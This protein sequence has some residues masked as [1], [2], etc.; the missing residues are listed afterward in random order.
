MNLPETPETPAS[1]QNIKGHRNQTIGS[2]SGNSRA[3]G[4]VE[5]NVYN[6]T[7]QKQERITSLFDLPL[8]V[9]D[10]VGRVDEL[11]QIKTALS[12]VSETISVPI[13]AVSGMAGVGKSALALHAGNSLS[14]N[15]PDAL[16][17]VDLQGDGD[18][19]KAPSDVLETWL[20]AFGLAPSEI[21]IT[22]EAKR[23]SFLTQIR[24][25]KALIV[26]DNA[27]NENQVRP[28]L[29]GGQDCAVLV[30]SR[31]SLTALK[32][33]QEIRLTPLPQKDSLNLLSTLAG[34]ARV[35][36]EYTAA[37]D[38]VRLCG[39]LPLAIRI[40]G[41]TLREK[42]HWGLKVDYLPLL[43]DEK[44][45]IKQLKQLRGEDVRASF[46]L[47]YQQLSKPEQ[48]LF[49]LLGALPS[50]FSI[51]AASATSKQPN[52][53]VKQVIEQLI[54]AQLLGVKLTESEQPR[55]QYHDLIRLFAKDLLSPEDL[56][57]SQKYFFQWC[58]ECAYNWDLALDSQNRRQILEE[59][60]GLDSNESL[61][62]AFVSAA[63][64]WFE[65]EKSNL[66]VAVDWGI[67]KGNKQE[68]VY[69][70]KSLVSFLYTRGYFHNMEKA[71]L[72]VLPLTKESENKL[73]ELNIINNLGEV[74]KAQG[75]FED[76]IQNYQRCLD[77]SRN[78]NDVSAQCH[79][80]QS[81]GSI[82][83]HTG[84]WEE[85]IEIY[86]ECLRMYRILND[87]YG[88]GNVL[89][90]LGTAY[91]AQG[92][93]QKALSKFNES[94]G[95]FRDL[96]DIHS[97]RI[98]LD[99]LGMLYQRLGRWEEAV[100]C[101][102]SSI[103]TYHD[104]GDLLGEANSLNRLG[105]IYREQGRLQE[106][107]D[108]HTAS[109]EIFRNASALIDEGICL[110]NIGLVY[111]A[112]GRWQDAIDKHTK[113]LEIFRKSGHP[114]GECQ[115]LCNLGV[116]YQ[117]QER[118]D[119]SIA[120][121]DASLSICRS[122][123]DLYG[124]AMILGNLGNVYQ[125]KGLVSDSIECQQK[126]L[127]IFRHLGDRQGEGKSLLSLA[128]SYKSQERWNAAVSHYR[129]GIKLLLKVGDS[130]SE[131]I[132]RIGLGKAYQ[133]QNRLNDAVA[134]YGQ[135]IEI[136]KSLGATHDEGT[137]LV[138][139]GNLYAMSYQYSNAIQ[140]WKEAK[141]KLHRS[142]P[143]FEKVSQLLKKSHVFFLKR[144]FLI[145]I[146][147]ILILYFITLSFIQGRQIIDQTTAFM[148]IGS[149]IY[150]VYSINKIRRT[151]RPLSARGEHLKVRGDVK[152]PLNSSCDQAL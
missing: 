102:S 120:Q 150:R 69:L 146:P 54:K 12:A 113:S 67:S 149:I 30:T 39:H 117:V 24:H 135:S 90:K 48:Q 60:Y 29:P 86:E 141:V 33:V 132:A 97:E 89:S 95:F 10:F 40:A 35:Q 133:K 109:L 107:L 110:N 104:F 76:A 151:L 36:T 98:V 82:Y 106:S 81:L 26:L 108:C 134:Q 25:Q 78:V 68:T 93:W 8:A 19:P 47:S 9:D 27:H 51:E 52:E 92:Q 32:G 123:G 34:S 15:F 14:E 21:P 140:C 152:D 136:F 122:L 91:Q 130:H 125:M 53:T 75:R 65:A 59:Q 105:L 11:K 74:Y 137:V 13:I 138:D 31:I 83:R 50:D 20:R 112:Q 99:N 56:E 57:T 28:L 44:K 18:S 111:R 71:L 7:Y 101:H 4:N 42:S 103:E 126:S 58:C 85:A 72:Q 87:R 1:D 131:G 94:L 79:I 61:E 127:D 3:F 2:M 5:G 70:V 62:K 37:E 118:L 129:E 55:Y 144:L 124:Q 23:S 139:I 63:I 38:I 119:D 88:E 128:T 100:E 114:Q 148:W 116:V 77:E 84:R 66:L 17:Y 73:E 43:R 145:L 142:S 16:L 22:L 46:S 96:G 143:A 64:R 115:A 147:E 121:Y 45:R 80:Q 6:V 41:G 49:S